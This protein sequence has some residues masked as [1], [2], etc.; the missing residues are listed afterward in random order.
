MVKRKSRLSKNARSRRISRLVKQNPFGDFDKDG[1][2]NIYDCEPT[3]PKKHGVEPSE[4]TWER[5]KALPIY[6]SDSSYNVWSEQVKYHIADLRSKRFAPIARQRLLTII[7]NYPELISDI[8]QSAP[9]QIIFISKHITDIPKET[10]RKWLKRQVV[11]RAS[12]TEYDPK[13]GVV[14]VS[15]SSEP[16]AKKPFELY[17][18]LGKMEEGAETAYHEL[19][20]I[21]Q[22]KRWGG[23]S[24]LSAE[25][26]KGKSAERPEEKLASVAGEKGIQKSARS[27]EESAMAEPEKFRPEL[28]EKAQA[29]LWSRAGAVMKGEIPEKRQGELS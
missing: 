23:K 5:L 29:K 28:A 18:A 2:P 8:E 15:L 1:V 21:K 26:G 3:N 16:Y 7:K 6:V 27:W 9:E 13:S 22:Y 20:H 12:P 11:G 25:M 17:G 24:K 14:F 10:V 19:E 4:T